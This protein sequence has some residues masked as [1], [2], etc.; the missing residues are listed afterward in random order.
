MYIVFKKI[1]IRSNCS[2][3]HFYRYLI[4]KASVSSMSYLLWPRHDVWCFRNYF[5]LYWITNS[6]WFFLKLDLDILWDFPCNHIGSGNVLAQT[7][8]QNVTWTNDDPILWL[9]ILSQ[10]HN[11]LNLSTKVLHDWVSIY[12]R[13]DEIR[14]NLKSNFLFLTQHFG[15]T[16]GFWILSSIPCFTIG[17]VSTSVD[18]TLDIP[19]EIKSMALCKTMV[20]PVH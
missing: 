17:C 8:L 3:F 13:P 11:E 16:T 5:F 9:P 10:G 7:R 14:N 4:L 6:F 19:Q 2:S 20:T 12:F 18:W 15:L 1:Q